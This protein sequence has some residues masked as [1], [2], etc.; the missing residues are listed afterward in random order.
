M[1]VQAGSSRSSSD[2]ASTSALSAT[3]LVEVATV[4]VV[5]AV[6]VVDA[7]V[8]VVEV[9]DVVDGALVAVLVVVDAFAVPPTTV[10]PLVTGTLPPRTG[11]GPA[12]A[13]SGDT[14]AG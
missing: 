7:V 12:G 3:F 2:C 8:D 11:R 6:L 9:V 5:P 14:G 1:E 4:F 10:S 13:T